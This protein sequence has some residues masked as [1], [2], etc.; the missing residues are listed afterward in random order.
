MG[1]DWSLGT[2]VVHRCETVTAGAVVDQR[3]LYFL[4]FERGV[5]ERTVNG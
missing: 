3:S 2:P 5:T 1:Y 4:V